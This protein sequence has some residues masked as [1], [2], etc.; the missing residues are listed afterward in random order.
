MLSMSASML[1]M[2]VWM[3]TRGSVW[4]S[5]RTTFGFTTET[6]RTQ[7]KTGMG[8]HDRFTFDLCVLCVFVVN[9]EMLT[10]RE[11][12]GQI[13]GGDGF[14]TTLQAGEMRRP[15]ERLLRRDARRPKLP[16]PGV[17]A[18]LAELLTAQLADERMMQEH[19]WRRTA[20]QPAE[21]DLAA[22]RLEQVLAP[23]HQVHLMP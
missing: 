18:R 7:S 21:Q 3:T 8:R 20:E 6:Q 1:P 5:T 11:Q 10:H 17:A 13:G 9:S 14:R 19:G 12:L 2:S 4:A 16:D 15:P 22:G 23:D